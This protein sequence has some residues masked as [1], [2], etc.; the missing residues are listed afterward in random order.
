MESS[1]G[2]PRAR[3][4][5]P[6]GRFIEP[7]DDG[8]DPRTGA[9]R[10]IDKGFAYMPGDSVTA[11]LRKTLEAGAA[12]L[13]APL[14]AALKADL[15]KIADNAGMENKILPNLDARAKT[16]LAAGVPSSEALLSGLW[17]N[18][19]AYAAHL[20]KRVKLSDVTGAE[21]Y[22]TRTFAVLK[23]AE[24]AMVAEPL[25]GRALSAKFQLPDGNW[26]VILGEGGVIITSY[27]FDPLKPGFEENHQRFGDSVYEQTLSAADR[28]L[29]AGIFARY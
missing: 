22:A 17:S 24:A 12:K 13:P 11:D 26:V 15:A 14:A 8:I 1:G 7:P 25:D 3:G 28:A 9:P 2:F 4:D 19:S 16:L 20:A 23:N 6:G 10:G 5:R 18:E 29:L 21:D 27:P